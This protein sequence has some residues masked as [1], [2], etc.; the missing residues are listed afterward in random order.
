M[1]DL[2]V[3]GA[4]DVASALN[5]HE[6]DVLASVRY[7]YE[8]HARG[9]TSLPHSG[10][11][12]FPDNDRD[13]IISLPAYLGGD[14]G[15]AGVKWIASVPSN[16]E[17]GLERA[18]AVVIVNDR[19]TGRPQAILEGSIISKKRTA[20]SAALAAEVLRRDRPPTTVGFVGC[21]PINAEVA[22][23]LASSWPAAHDIQLFDLSTERAT[24]F[25]R[26]IAEERPSSNVSI[27]S[28]LH[29]VLAECDVI[30]FGTTAGVPHVANLDGCRPGTTILHVSL[31]DLAPEIILDQPRVLNVVDD[32]DHVCRAQ[33][34]IHLASASGD[35]DHS[36]VHSSLG[37]LLLG[38]ST[39]PTDLASRIA[40]FSPFGLG[41][42]DLAVA[43]MVLDAART[44]GR[45]TVIP[46]FLP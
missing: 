18:S 1:R 27:A 14:V 22:R 34:S 15:L 4:A 44:D 46:S 32:F 30:S 45:G 36:F 37:D 20:A 3:L 11:L 33:T 35:D 39:L 2:T 19:L 13:R 41:I 8:A 12:R 5:G 10:F 38:R 21:G 24:E 6:R 25:G 9:E 7:A 31:R 17:R 42:L 43:G 28:S 29:A 40:I 23:F 26:G 16:V